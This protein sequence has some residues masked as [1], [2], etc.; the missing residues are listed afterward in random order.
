MM[1]AGARNVE[2]VINAPQSDG[3][4]AHNLG[5]V[6]AL[7]SSAVPW[8]IAH[9]PSDPA[10]Y[11]M[12][13]QHPR[14]VVAVVDADA[15]RPG[16]D[17][18]ARYSLPYAPCKASQR[19]ICSSPRM[20]ARMRHLADQNVQPAS[21]PGRAVAAAGCGGQRVARLGAGASLPHR[22]MPT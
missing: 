15:E 10:D 17:A 3:A 13:T 16:C 12:T 11:V 7:Q 5:A 22:A 4:G 6:D 18:L 21:A 8:R 1:H 2:A 19:N 9:S 20:T 14:L